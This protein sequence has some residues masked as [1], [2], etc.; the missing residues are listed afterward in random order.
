LKGAHDGNPGGCNN[1]PTREGRDP[2]G[3]HSV[4]A[5]LSEVGVIAVLLAITTTYT[6]LIAPGLSDAEY[7]QFGEL[8]GYYV[9][10][11]AGAIF[12]FL[13]VMW[14]ARKLASGFIIHGVLVGVVSVLLTVGFVATARPEHRVM[15]LIAFALRIVAG[16]VGG[17]VAQRRYE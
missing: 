4:A 15:Y 7:E 3:T 11:T 9:A 16:Y 12:T 6:F 13:V 17:R 2:L 5:I 1:S 10:P 14:M 8:A